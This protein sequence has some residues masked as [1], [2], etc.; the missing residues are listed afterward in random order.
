MI[1]LEDLEHRLPETP[2]PGMLMA[3]LEANTDDE[4]GG[5][6]LIYARESFYPDD[7]TGWPDVDDPA[8]KP[9]WGARCTCTACREDFWAGWLKGGGITMAVGEDGTA[10]PGIPDKDSPDYIVGWKDD[11]NCPCPLCGAYLTV[12]HR[13]NL[14][15]GRTYQ[16]ML[17]SVERVDDL[18]VVMSWVVSRQIDADGVWYEGVRPFAAAVL[19]SNGSLRRYQHKQMTG[20]GCAAALSEWKAATKWSDPFQI[21]YYSW[22]GDCRKKRG[23]W[24]WQDLPELAGSTAEKTG[25]AEYIQAGGRWPNVYLATWRKS[26]AVENLMKC[27]MARAVTEKINV[28]VDAA[29]SCGYDKRDAAPEILSIAD[30]NYAKPRQMLHF[31]RAEVAACGAWHWGAAKAELWMQGVRAGIWDAGYAETFERMAN[32][33]VVERLCRY[34]GER[35]DGQ[36]FEPLEKWDAYLQKQYGKRGLNLQTGFEL[37]FDYRVELAAQVDAPDAAELWPRNLRAAHDRIFAA[38]KQREDPE[39]VA[40]FLAVAETWSALEWSDGEICIRLPRCNNDLIAEG[41]T[42]HHC[43][44]GYGKSHLSGKLVLFVRHARR[45]ERSWYTL[46]INVSGDRPTRIQLHGYGNEWAHGAHL[47]IPQRVLDFVDRWET[48]ILAPAFRA[49]RAEQAKAK[50]PRRSRK[51]AA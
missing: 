31:T 40:N 37:L 2:R 30:L 39:S 45:P 4:L 36:N 43:V 48:E 22:D 28:A 51:G 44:G 12:T 5:E 8:A 1:N 23:A 50:T 6:M 18:A 21:K 17:G 7:F 15:N 11:D 38:K 10:Y 24:M 29:T 32:L 20:Y 14:R 16:L 33:Y 46:N 49:V 35:A 25:L 47:H 34:V 3:A 27:V 42:L 9:R 41:H 19:T 26:P 13:K